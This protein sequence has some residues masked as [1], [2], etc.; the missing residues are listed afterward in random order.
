MSVTEPDYRALVKEA[1][2]QINALKRRLHATDAARHAP[3]AI[4]GYGCRLPGDVQDER[5]YWALMQRGADASLFDQQ[6]RFNLQ[7]IWDPAERRPGKTYTR[8]LSL[9]S[10]YEAFDARFFGVSDADA[11]RLD[12]QQRL[13][14]ETSWEAFERA[15]LVPDRMGGVTGSFVGLS[16]QEFAQAASLQRQPEDF[17][18]SDG[19]GSS[20]AVAAGR[21]NYF[22]GFTGPAQA[23]DT[24]CSSVL[25][26]V[27][28]AMQ[29][30]RLGKL[31]TALAGGVNLII[32][33][34][35]MLVFAQAGVLSAAGRQRCFDAAAD[36]Y[37]RAEACTLLVLKRLDDAL[38]QG[39][40]VLAVLNG[41]AVNHSGHSQGITTPHQDGQKA[42]M[43][44]ALQDAGL[45]A[46]AVD[47]VEAHATG[48]PLG[49]FIEL[50][51]LQDVYGQAR[52]RPLWITSVKARMGHAE[53]GSAGP[54]LLSAL[55]QLRA[56]RVTAQHDFTQPNSLFDWQA[57]PFRVPTAD[58]PWPGQ[59]VAAVSA[60]GYSGSNAH[61][62]LSRVPAP[63]PLADPP[64]AGLKLSARSGAALQALAQRWHAFLADADETALPAVLALANGGRTD[65]EWRTWLAAPSLGRLREGCARLAAGEGL[66]EKPVRNGKPLSAP[67]LPL[68]ADDQHAL[69][70][71]WCQGAQVPWR[72][73]YPQLPA[74]DLPTYPFQRT[75]YWPDLSADSLPRTRLKRVTSHDLFLGE[76][77]AGPDGVC[78]QGYWSLDHLTLL[79]P[80]RVWDRQ[81]LP[82]LWPV[83]AAWATR[84]RT[85]DALCD[86]AWGEWC[87]LTRDD[88][89]PLHSQWKDTGL[90]LHW[91]TGDRGDWKLAFRAAPGLRPVS[92]GAAIEADVQRPSDPLPDTPHL[93]IRTWQQTPRRLTGLLIGDFQPAPLGEWVAPAEA[94]AVEKW[95]NLLLFLQE[96]LDLCQCWSRPGHRLFPGSADGFWLD[97]ERLIWCLAR[98]LPVRV[99]FELLDDVGGGLQLNLSLH[100]EAG[101][102]LLLMHSLVLFRVDAQ[103]FAAPAPLQ[104]LARAVLPAVDLSAYRALRETMQAQPLETAA[105]A[106]QDLLL[107]QLS[108][109]TGTLVTADQSLFALGIDSLWAMDFRARLH[110]ELHLTLPLTFLL[111]GPGVGQLAR[112]LAQQL[113]APPEDSPPAPPF[114]P[115]PATDE[116]ELTL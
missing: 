60:F 35:M 19:P 44:A 98:R 97:D 105:Q 111:K 101:E 115:A 104:H 39:L 26:C 65:F 17:S 93:R 57:T 42:V 79:Q 53:T 22:Y 85:A 50:S 94:A 32:N 61:V 103:R 81:G 87:P 1:L 47:L 71:Q 25:V 23:I 91:R 83:I 70:Q 56:G 113:Q 18:A 73:L 55:W 63:P 109:L 72:T 33:P 59:G 20:L 51:A 37:V 2:V 4:V 90:R 64:L 10:G 34:L 95:I 16:T 43:Q 45:A 7:S 112:F 27:H 11:Q 40:P 107:A 5:S 8:A 13:L 48:T 89:H 9:L 114:V 36:G 108:A 52:P 102:P 15:G 106:L 58:L 86:L 84:P 54:A 67:V 96:T 92:A 41:A 76:R 80:Y 12:P 14:L 29:A 116:I 24:A 28:D 74:I 30:L 38:T 3:I 110:Q 88:C 75:G 31:D 82:P 66:P 69:W 46:D 78:F 49:D 100:G 6:R 21:L 68:H 62:I 99:C 77:V